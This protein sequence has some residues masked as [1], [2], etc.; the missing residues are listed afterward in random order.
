MYRVSAGR[1]AQRSGASLYAAAT[2][3]PV[4]ALIHV[5]AVPEHFEEWWGYG[6]YFL[7]SWVFQGAYAPALLLRSRPSRSLGRDPCR[8]VAVRQLGKEY[9]SCLTR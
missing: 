3:S 2:L 5:V 7:V 8:A 4:A 9:T 1:P 6:A